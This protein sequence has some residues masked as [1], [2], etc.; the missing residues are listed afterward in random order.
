MEN[1]IEALRAYLDDILLAVPD[2]YQRR[3]GYTHLYGVA[4]ACA[5]I[6]LARS[7]NAELATMAGMLHDIATYQYGDST[8]HAAKSAVLAREILTK[9]D[10]ATPAEIDSISAAIH[11][12]SDKGNTHDSFSEVLIDADVMQHSLYNI[13]HPVAAYEAARFQKLIAEFGLPPNLPIIYQEL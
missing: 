6:A 10:L 5:W 3:V 11:N 9:L 1:R 7:E 2:A 4:Q 8:D 13:T 12:H